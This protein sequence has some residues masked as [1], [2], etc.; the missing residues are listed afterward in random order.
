M[1]M[2]VRACLFLLVVGAMGAATARAASVASQV[3]QMTGSATRMVWMRE[4]GKLVFF[5]TEDKRGEIERDY[6]MKASRPVITPDGRRVVFICY[7]RWASYIVDW[8][9]TKATKL[10][11]GRVTFVRQDER[12]D[13]WIYWQTKRNAIRT[14]PITSPERSE[15]VWQFDWTP[16]KG[17][18]T[19]FQTSADGRVAGATFPWP[20]NGLALLPQDGGH[21]AMLGRGC[22]PQIARDNS[23]RFMHC[24]DGRHEGVRM[25][26]P[27]ATDVW[28]VEMQPNPEAR[29]C[30]CPRWANDTRFFITT[31]RPGGGKVW[32]VYLAQFSDDF[33]KVERWLT[34]SRRGRNGQADMWVRAASRYPAAGD[35]EVF[36]A[37]RRLREGGGPTPN[38]WDDRG[39]DDEP[40]ERWP[41]VS[42]GLV[43]VYESLAGANEIRDADGQL[44]RRCVADL[45]GRAKPAEFAS[46]DV[47][48]G[49]LDAQ[50]ADAAL[51]RGARGSNA[52]T[53][54][55]WL[56]PRS[57]RAGANGVIATF[58]PDISPGN[59]TLEQAGERLI[60]RLRST[61]GGK[62]ARPY[63]LPG[64][65]T[66]QTQHVAVVI[67]EGRVRTY[68]NGRRAGRDVTYRGD[69]GNW[70]QA[71]LRFGAR[72]VLGGDWRGRIE[73]IALHRRALTRD[74]VARQFN[75]YRAKVADRKPPRRFTVRGKLVETS[76][77]PPLSAIEPYPRCLVVNTYEVAGAGEAAGRIL[78]A[79]WAYLADQRVPVHSEVG[80]M[81]PLV[82]ERMEDHPHLERE[83]VI[84]EALDLDASLYV[85]VG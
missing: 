25:Y 73:G 20:S 55:A 7:D 85:D 72:W 19:N 32:G 40:R 29:G 53:F 4:H 56:T 78:V 3:R 11:D 15:V 28:I 42:D 52:L 31:D 26:A 71:K 48:G 83:R 75:A 36:A 79:H 62:T 30:E 38:E 8:A 14:A 45:G 81:Y 58:S 27:G 39:G 47:S 18:S 1:R 21:F 10:V 50:A 33:R 64:Q 59:F 41:A 57:V 6:G 43:F 44:L 34:V 68:V 16:R 69:L 35:D 17:K 61:G 66:A 51:L 80:K 13:Q 49:T 9:G 37:L 63:A 12:G 22:W 84:N 46:V 54:E 70:T 5:D 60:L 2:V 67:G 82:I 23:Y 77:V 76:T 24:Y 74:E 65:L